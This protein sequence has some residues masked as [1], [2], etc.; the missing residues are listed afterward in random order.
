MEKDETPFDCVSR[1][2]QE[3]L[4]ISIAASSI[5][6]Q[7]V[8]PAMHDSSLVAY[9]MVAPINEEQLA[10]IV[11][12]DEGQGWKMMKIDEFMASNEVVEPLKGRLSDYL[13]STN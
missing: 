6:W 4:G 5:L 11:F 7:K 9:F 3:E 12:G 8:Y 13:D 10:S 1:E 2:V